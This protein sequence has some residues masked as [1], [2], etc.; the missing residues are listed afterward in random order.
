[1]ATCHNVLSNLHTAPAGL[2]TRDIGE[3]TPQAG[4][5]TLQSLLRHTQSKPLSPIPTSEMALLSSPRARPDLVPDSW[6]SGTRTRARQSGKRRGASS[7][8]PQHSQRSGRTR[9]PEGGTRHRAGWDPGAAG[10]DVSNHASGRRG[11][12]RQ[13]RPWAS[14]RPPAHRGAAWAGCGCSPGARRS[15]LLH[16]AVSSWPAG[17][18][19]RAPGH[20]A[21]AP[22]RSPAASGAAAAAVAAAGA[23]PPGR[24]QHM[25]GRGLRPSRLDHRPQRGRAGSVLPQLTPAPRSWRPG[26]HLHIGPIKIPRV[27]SRR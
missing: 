7:P 3:R 10:R 9:P 24:G 23:A 26:Y 13:S 17:L 11:H 19:S 4:S 20:A 12:P 16:A 14:R 1:M 5:S 8:E 6:R 15:P 2:Q 27:T 25:G 22:A 18:P 21:A